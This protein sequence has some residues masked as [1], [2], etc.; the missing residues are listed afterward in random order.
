[1]GALE[2]FQT[3]LLVQRV[4]SRTRVRIASQS[5][6]QILDLIIQ[7]VLHERRCDGLVQAYV[8]SL[9]EDWEEAAS[10][11]F[12]P[13]P[14]NFNK[15]G[16]LRSL[17]KIE[18]VM[19]EAYVDRYRGRLDHPVDEDT[20]MEV[21]MYPDPFPEDRVPVEVAVAVAE[22]IADRDAAEGNAMRR[23]MMW[24]QHRK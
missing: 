5:R 2:A 22:A 12:D 24:R 23:E 11:E 10:E 7:K 14:Q 3:S 17:A 8:D 16:I 4:A 18:K 9:V 15:I 13:T 19:A 21:W 20:A 1:M 6:A